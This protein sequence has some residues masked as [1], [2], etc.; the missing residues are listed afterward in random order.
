MGKNIWIV[1]HYALPPNMPGGTRHID[2]CKRL[3]KKGHT[4]TIFASSFHYQKLQD[5]K[6]YENEN[7][8][9]EIIEGVNFVW[10]KTFQY[11]KNNW[12]RFVNMLSYTKKFVDYVKRNNRIQTP[13][14]IVG[15]SVHLFSVYG[16]YKASKIKKAKFFME[17]R[18][19]WPQTLIDL[20]VNKY[21]PLILL[22][23]KLETF[24]YKKAEKIIT[25]LPASKQYFIGKGVP[26]DKIYWLPNGVD[27]G[28]FDNIYPLKKNSKFTVLYAGVI[29]RANKLELLIDA[30]SELTNSNRNDVFFKVIG[31]GQEKQR[32]VNTVEERKLKNI[33]FLDAINK[34]E[35]PQELVN[36]DV[37]FFG[38]EDSPVFKYGISS[39]KLFDYLMSGKP[40]IFSCK[41]GNDPV[42]EADAGISIPP[43]SPVDLLNAIS[44]LQ[45]KREQELIQMGE[46]GRKYVIKHHD[47]DNLV[48]KF[49][50]IL[51]N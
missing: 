25:L 17:V 32:L 13:D 1:N 16:A 40:I 41:A 48:D 45:N 5:F 10:F 27:T 29:G 4:V 20:G 14:I 33:E 28:K 2:L 8:I 6:Q 51:I 21:H 19:I 7:Y 23:S 22:F 34:N 46:R 15:S 37:L 12:K 49:E 30:A 39:N 31:Q 3:V 44:E 42:Q 18:D 24:L 38:L 26:E 36:A 11:K 43:N 50:K 9:E 35:V 47:M